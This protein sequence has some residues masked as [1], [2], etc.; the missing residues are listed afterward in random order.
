MA[1][2]TIYAIPGTWEI[3][4]G[5]YPDSPIGML[6][7]VTDLLNRSIF[8]V[9]HVNYPA[10]FGPIAN[11]GEPPLSQLGSPSYADSVQMGVDEVVR[12]I[13]SK[14]GKFGVIGYSQG[15]AV[16][17]QVG[18]EVM[19]GRLAH[20]KSDCLWLHTF[21]SPHRRAGHTFH[22]GNPLAYGGI[23]ASD[24]IGGFGYPGTSPIDWFDYGLPDDIYVNANPDSYLEAGYEAV[25]EMSLADP[26][27]W[28]QAVLESIT[29]GEL[30]EMFADITDPVTFARKVANTAVAVARFG[31]SHVRYGIDEVVPGQT[32]LEHSA[33]HLNFWGARR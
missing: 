22:L 29:T 1:N 7:G 4:P 16:A 18:R 11:N 15:G 12:L 3:G 26:L 20:R 32:A 10:R 25:R 27:G 5:N 21:A 24:P 30:G 2:K 6:K 31:D 19:S 8:D 9:Q 13:E 33:N 14:P 23:I 17:S 28:G